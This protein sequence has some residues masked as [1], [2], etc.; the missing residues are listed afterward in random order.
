MW[1]G[2]RSPSRT[3]SNTGE[4]NTPLD[5]RV[6]SLTPLLSFQSIVWRGLLFSAFPYERTSG[7]VDLVGSEFQPGE[8]G[9]SDVDAADSLV[10]RKAPTGTRS[11]R[12]KLWVSLCSPSLSG[13][14]DI[15]ISGSES[16]NVES[17]TS[18]SLIGSPRAMTGGVSDDGSSEGGGNEE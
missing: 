4:I 17:R 16:R 13:I 15:S 2:V 1:V 3:G 7:T 18:S 5:L 10:R 9:T 6:F 8:V 11:Q 12:L 14:V